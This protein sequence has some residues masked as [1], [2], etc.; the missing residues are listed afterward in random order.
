MIVQ[1]LNDRLVY[2]VLKDVFAGLPFRIA[3][4]MKPSQVRS[5]IEQSSLPAVKDLRRN[6]ELRVVTSTAHDMLVRGIYK[7]TERAKIRFPD[8]FGIAK[9]RGAAL[10]FRHGP[11]KPATERETV[12][13]AVVSGEG[14]YL[15]SYTD[16]R[17]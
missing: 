9:P 8:L 6:H 3:Q 2:T 15:L 4:T 11:A 12:V 7:D 13:E 17:N 16:L 1:Q 10:V 5:A 14:E